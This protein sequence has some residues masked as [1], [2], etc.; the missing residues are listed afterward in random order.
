[1]QLEILTTLSFCSRLSVHLVLMLSIGVCFWDWCLLVNGN[2]S[3]IEYTWIMLQHSF[4]RLQLNLPCLQIE[5]AFEPFCLWNHLW[6]L[7]LAFD[8]I[9]NFKNFQNNNLSTNMKVPQT[10]FNFS[11]FLKKMW[12]QDFHYWSKCFVWK[13][14]LVWTSLYGKVG[15]HNIIGYSHSAFLVSMVFSWILE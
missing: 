9:T 10:S 7:V 12:A 15:A 6:L 4:N 1:M 8:C 2:R 13:S 3:Y 5:W 11:S 14:K